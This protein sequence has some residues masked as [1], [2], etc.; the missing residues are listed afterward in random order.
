[1]LDRLR[2]SS[3]S[4][5]RYRGRLRSR[6][7]LWWTCRRRGAALLW[8]FRITGVGAPTAARA[9]QVG[10][11]TTI[12]ARAWFSLTSRDARIVVGEECMINDDLVITCNQLVEIGDGVGIGNRCTIMDHEHDPASYLGRALRSGDLPRIDYEKTTAAP[13]RIGS[14]VH[15]GN[16]VV[17]MTGVTIGEGAIIGANAVVTRS[18]EP[19]QIVAGVPA[20]ALRTIT[21]DDLSS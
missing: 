2:I 8:P 10:A 4:A 13:V 16:N 17:I 21:V 5:R 19:Y 12:G 3:R 15:V 6:L 11:R 14:G 20:R 18:V 9:L 1:M 7:A